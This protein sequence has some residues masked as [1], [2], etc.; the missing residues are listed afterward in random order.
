MEGQ[1][2]LNLFGFFLGQ[3][4]NEDRTVTFLFEDL[5]NAFNLRGGFSGSVDDFRNPLPLA[6]LRINLGIAQIDKGCL[7]QAEG[8]LFNGQGSF[9]DLLK[10]LFKGSHQRTSKS[11]KTPS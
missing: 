1:G 8:G 6:P 11:R 4:G 5:G 2:L 9:L 7:A 3:A 10:N